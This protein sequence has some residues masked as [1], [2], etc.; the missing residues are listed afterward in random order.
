MT[1]AAIE[2]SARANA[3]TT[4]RVIWRAFG[5]TKQEIDEL[6]EALTAEDPEP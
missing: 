1:R 6:E 2:Q 4:R 3:I 5:K